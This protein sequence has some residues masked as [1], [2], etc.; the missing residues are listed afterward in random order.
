MYARLPNGGC[1]AHLQHERDERVG[2]CADPE[3]CAAPLDDEVRQVL[4]I[5][6]SVGHGEWKAAGKSDRSRPVGLR[7]D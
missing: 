2:E 6:S 3:L 7:I 5:D 1:I 4:I